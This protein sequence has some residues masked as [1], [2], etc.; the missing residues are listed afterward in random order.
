[1]LTSLLR[2]SFVVYLGGCVSRPLGASVACNR[3]GNNLNGVSQSFA[4]GDRGTSGKIHPLERPPGRAASRLEAPSSLIMEQSVCL[5][6]Q[7]VHTRTIVDLLSEAK[8]KVC[9][10]SG[11]KQQ[12]SVCLMPA[13]PDG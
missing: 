4:S 9:V 8:P 12:S 11:V 6:W 10:R 1:M 13:P 3:A 2:E 5:E 7:E